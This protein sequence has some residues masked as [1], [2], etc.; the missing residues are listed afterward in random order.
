MPKSN[1]NE[2]PFFANSLL[3]LL[4]IHQ[5]KSLKIFSYWIICISD[6]ILSRR[7]TISPSQLAARLTRVVADSLLPVGC[8]SPQVRYS[9]QAA[10]LT[11]VVADSLLRRVTAV[12]RYGTASR[13]PGSKT[14]LF[15]LPVLVCKFEPMWRSCGAGSAT[16]LK[17]NGPN[18]LSR[19]A[20]PAH[21]RFV[22]Q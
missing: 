9:Q 1:C 3:A 15:H 20:A 11:R 18:W 6:H 5:M 16:L 17:A 7:M 2:W 4:F 10:R 12:R 19:L 22:D 8:S 21:R 13:R 14:V